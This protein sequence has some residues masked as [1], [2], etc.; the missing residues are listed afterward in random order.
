MASKAPWE[1]KPE[2]VEKQ[3]VGQDQYEDCLS[4]RITGSAA[5][6]GLGV[7]SYYTG[8]RNLKQQEKAIMR[9]ASKYKMGS[10]QLGI[11]TL[12]ASL[13]GVGLYRAF[14]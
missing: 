8:M 14:N 1:M 10:R 7:Y 13:I 3:M 5:F 11:A 4:C 12:S 9:S 6:M 2:E